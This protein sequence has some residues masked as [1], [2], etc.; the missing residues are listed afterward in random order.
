M[1]A[2]QADRLIGVDTHRDSHTAA[3]VESQTGVVGASETAAADRRGHRRLLAFADE[4]APGRRAWAIE[5]TGSYG[6]GLAAFLSERGERVLE[7]DR[8]QRRA[9]RSGAKSDEL[10]AIRAAREALARAHPAQP[11]ARGDRE[12][13]RV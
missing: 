5:S 6:A 1:L 3:V 2:E 8:P 11:R 4:Q 13:V 9:R 10:D 7:V 12:A